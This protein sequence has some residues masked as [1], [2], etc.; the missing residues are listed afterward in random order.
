MRL[1][2]KRMLLVCW[3]RHVGDQQPSDDLRNIDWRT[4][5]SSPGHVG[6]IETDRRGSSS[7]SWKRWEELKQEQ[8]ELDDDLARRKIARLFLREEQVG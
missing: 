2:Y 5:G 7:T 8:P 3:I 6:R 1:G 4:T